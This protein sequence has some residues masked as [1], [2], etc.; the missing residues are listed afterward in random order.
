[1][2]ESCA[3]EP[4]VKERLGAE[5]RKYAL[6]SGYLF[7]CFSVILFYEASLLPERDAG[8]LHYSVALGKALVLGKFILLGEALRL[9]TRPYAPSLLHRI[10]WKSVALLALLVLLTGIEEVIVG[11]VH[12][13]SIRAILSGIGSRP[14]THWLGPV[15]LVL[16]VLIPLTATSELDRALG[17]GRLKQLLLDHSQR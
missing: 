15:L 12:G 4:G 17:A 11:L 1:M 13:E 8:L 3:G 7:V 5:F 14:W 9:G 16:L 2:S 10:A 6:V